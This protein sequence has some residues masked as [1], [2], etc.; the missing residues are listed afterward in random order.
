MGY[1]VQSAAQA[2]SRSHDVPGTGWLGYSS[3]LHQLNMTT[4]WF[5]GVQ[6]MKYL[7]VGIPNDCVH[8]IPCTVNDMQVTIDNLKL[9]VNSA[10]QAGVTVMVNAYPDWQ[11]MDLHAAGMAFGLTN[12][13]SEGDYAVL[14][15]MHR[16]QISAMPGVVYVD[17]WKGNFTTVDGLHPKDVNQVEAAKR[18]VKIIEELEVGAY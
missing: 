16:D 12:I 1:T 18:I 11:D 15:Q 3:Q 4:T 2:G 7:V 9:A 13:I 6:R 10:T 8:S 5:D 17:A 14:I